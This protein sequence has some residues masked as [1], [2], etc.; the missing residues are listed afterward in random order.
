VGVVCGGCDTQFTFY[1]HDTRKIAF[2]FKRNHIAKIVSHG[3]KADLCVRL[4]EILRNYPEGLSDDA[5]A[6]MI[7]F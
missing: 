4:R 5:G 1:T 7:R 6:D 2:V 3:Q